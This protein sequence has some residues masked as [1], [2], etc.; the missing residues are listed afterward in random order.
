MFKK[1]CYVCGKK[2]QD[3]YNGKC[4]QCF[5]L[6]TPPIDELKPI[7]FKYCNKCK[8]IAYNNAYY[9]KEEIENNIESIVRKNIKINNAY[10]LNDLWIENLTI[11]NGKISFDISVDC[12]LKNQA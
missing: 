4:E 8:K 12:S 1:T 7:N 6:D 10:I 11:E 3:V 9:T 5:K 2:T